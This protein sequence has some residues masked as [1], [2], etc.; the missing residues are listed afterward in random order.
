MDAHGHHDAISPAVKVL[1][2]S[3]GVFHGVR[4]DQS[5]AALVACCEAEGWPV[6]APAVPAAGADAVANALQ[7]LVDGFHGL[8]LTTGGTGFGPR[9]ATPEG[10]L[11][12]W[13]AWRPG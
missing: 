12:L 8:V 13:T 5:G 2:V 7:A 1:T 11:P 4:E 3:D 9:D 10:T 6:V